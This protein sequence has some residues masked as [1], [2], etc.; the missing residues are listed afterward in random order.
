[1]FRGRIESASVGIRGV[2]LACVREW[3]SECDFVR[4]GLCLS[5]GK[6]N[7]YKKVVDQVRLCKRE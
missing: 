7:L 6:V 2:T 1:M 3:L 4:E 5:E